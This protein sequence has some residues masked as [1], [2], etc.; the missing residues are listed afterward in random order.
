MIYLIH[1]LYFEFILIDPNENILPPVSTVLQDK[2]SY[3][4]TSDEVNKDCLI[5]CVTTQSD[6]TENE[7]N[8]NL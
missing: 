8:Q 2:R 1:Q 7:P 3:S 4:S 5:D 6:E